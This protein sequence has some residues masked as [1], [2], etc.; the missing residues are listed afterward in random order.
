MDGRMQELEAKFYLRDLSALSGQLPA[1]GAE[2]IHP[3]ILE[4]NLRFDTPDGALQRQLKVL[5]LR[6]SHSVV[7]TYKG[8]A[9]VI[10]GASQR[11]EVETEVGDFDATQALLQALGFQV[12]R[13]YEKY[14]TEYRFNEL[15]ITL[16]ELPFG[17][18]IEIEGPAVAEIQQVA[19]RLGLDWTANITTNYLALLDRVKAYR[20]LAFRDLTFENFRGLK[21][22]PEE[23]GVRPAD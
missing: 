6:Q 19:G 2:I 9:Q 17:D 4:T 1:M 15:V 5:R 14:R 12:S 8:P 23:L 7:L 13:I 22:A 3:R 16:D 21:I 11:Q 18:F 10:E 20:D